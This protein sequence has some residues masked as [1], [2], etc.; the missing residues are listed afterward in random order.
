MSTLRYKFSDFL[1]KF[2]LISALK[3]YNFMSYYIYTLYLFHIYGVLGFWGL[4]A[5]YT[6]SLPWGLS[7]GIISP[8]AR[9]PIRYLAT[10]TDNMLLQSVPFAALPLVAGSGIWFWVL[11]FTF[12]F[13]FFKTSLI[14]TFKTTMRGP[15]D[16][17]DNDFKIRGSLSILIYPLYGACTTRE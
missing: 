16:P 6:F 4:V 10:S 13:V 11:A 1:I 2:W 14:Y 17:P 12:I 3:Y 5:F 8:Y 15:G 9:M 7:T